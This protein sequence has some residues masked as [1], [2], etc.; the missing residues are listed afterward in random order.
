MGFLKGFIEQAASGAY[1]GFAGAVFLV[2]G[3][4]ADEYRAG[5]GGA[6]AEDDLGGV[7]IEIAA[8]TVFG[9]GAELRERD[10][11]GEEVGGGAGAFAGRFHCGWGSNECA[12]GA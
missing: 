12:G 8:V 2:A 11:R 5:A 3:L 1:E 4:L 10:A 6:F 9:G 7:A